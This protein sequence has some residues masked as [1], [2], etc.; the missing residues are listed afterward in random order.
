MRAAELVAA[1][2]LGVV[3]TGMGSDGKAG[4]EEIKRRGGKNF[5][6]SKDTSVVFGMPQSAISTGK[7]DRVLPLAAIPREISRWASGEERED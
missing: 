7:V 6:E 2:I 4:V 1:L 5:A 3:L